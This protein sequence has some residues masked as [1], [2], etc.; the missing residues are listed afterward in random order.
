M[1]GVPLTPD[2]G[3]FFPP[4]TDIETEIKCMLLAEAQ[5]RRLHSEFGWVYGALYVDKITNQ[6]WFRQEEEGAESEA[7]GEDASSQMI[8][9]SKLELCS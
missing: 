3:P 8:T 5:T 7:A 4:D 6:N 9:I 2:T 1:K